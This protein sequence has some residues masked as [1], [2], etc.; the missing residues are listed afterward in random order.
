MCFYIAQE[1]SSACVGRSYHRDGQGLE[2]VISDAPLGVCARTRKDRPGRLLISYRPEEASPVGCRNRRRA[3]LSQISIRS[4]R[5]ALV[6]GA[7]QIQVSSLNQDA[8]QFSARLGS[9]LGCYQRLTEPAVPRQH[10]P[11]S[12]EKSSVI[13][14]EPT[15]YVTFQYLH[16][17]R[18]TNEN[19]ALCSSALRLSSLFENSAE[20]SPTH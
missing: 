4:R 2:H 9:E 19:I 1:T 8:H 3:N 11:D 7:T 13:T 6:T 16:Q 20:P 15:C 10:G 5:I 12:V 17:H 14:A 18:G